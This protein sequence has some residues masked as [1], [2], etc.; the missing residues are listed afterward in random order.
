[1]I[2][3]KPKQ[4]EKLLELI[5]RML[6]KG[7]VIDCK[8]RVRLYDLHLIKMRGTL[9]LSSF[10]GAA[11]H[12][13]DFPS[14]VN[15]ETE[16]WHRLLTKVGCPQCNKKIYEEEIEKGGCPWCGYSMGAS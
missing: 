12:G 6:N 14:E 1:M 9:I 16:A 3:L 15:Y 2:H 8:I 13:L 11:K 5:D 4:S 10:E 7:V